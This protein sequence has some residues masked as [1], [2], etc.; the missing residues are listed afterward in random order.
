MLK[1]TIIDRNPAHIQA[2]ADAFGGDPNVSYALMDINH[3]AGY[4]ALIT[5]GNS[6]GIMDGGFDQAVTTLFGLK[7][8]AVVQQRIKADHL[9]ELNVGDAILLTSC[10]PHLVYAPTMRVPMQITCTDNVYRAF[11][12]ALLQI[13]LHNKKQSA[14][15][16][17]CIDKVVTPLL[18]AG[19]GK[20]PPAAAAKQMKL[21]WD[22]IH[23]KHSI[24]SWADADAL[25]AKIG[26]G[27]GGDPE[28]F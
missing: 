24:S 10:I 2:A 12:A 3:A 17:P 23:G 28:H 9:G 14:D 19:A 16:G 1:L 26:L 25:Q 11:R 13:V 21:A 4:D 27:L 5:P 15:G 6:F 7:I 22:S 8:E 20:F 18:G